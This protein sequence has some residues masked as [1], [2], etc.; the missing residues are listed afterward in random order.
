MSRGRVAGED[1]C[2]GLP[3]ARCA[4]FK[5]DELVCLWI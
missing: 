3:E 1:V 2:I 4:R 5:E